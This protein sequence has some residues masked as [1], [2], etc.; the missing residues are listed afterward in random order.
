[1]EDEQKIIVEIDEKGFIKATA[2]GMSGPACIDSVTRLLKEIAV[3]TDI[4]KTD[5]YYG[6]VSRKEGTRSSIESRGGR[7]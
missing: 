2:K 5:E 6:H 4:D 7:S 1:M 3:V